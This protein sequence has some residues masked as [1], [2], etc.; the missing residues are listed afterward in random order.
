[1][2]YGKLREIIGNK[3]II[4]IGEKDLELFNVVQIDLTMV[5]YSDSMVQS[6]GI[7][8]DVRNIQNGENV[9]HVWMG[10]L[11]MVIKFV[12]PVELLVYQ[13]MMLIINTLV[14]MEMLVLNKDV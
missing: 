12:N 8:Q 14:L 7:Y 4:F 2:H 6:V 11:K 9:I 13:H 1:M 5:Q 10:I 3:K